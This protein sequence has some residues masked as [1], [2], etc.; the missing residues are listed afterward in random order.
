MAFKMWNGLK[1]QARTNFDVLLKIA[2]LRGLRI[3]GSLLLVDESQ[4]MD[5]CQID[6]VIRQQVASGKCTFV[7]GDAAQS[8][9]Y[10]RGAQPEHLMGLKPN[11]AISLTRTWRFGERIARVANVILYCK[12]RSPQIWNPYFI[13]GGG[14]CEGEVT[15]EPLY[16]LCQEEKVP[17][18]VAKM[19]L[20]FS[21]LFWLWA[22]K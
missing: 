5:A 3:P 4:D 20:F 10:F 18:T 1:T 21:M 14:G 13:E 22:L 7:V 15:I 19:H 11:Q 2:Q 17:V 6:W 12:S 16:P 9:Y 8:V